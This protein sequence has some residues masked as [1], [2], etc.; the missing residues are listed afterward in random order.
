MNYRHWLVVFLICVSVGFTN[1]Q[2]NIQMLGKAEMHLDTKQGKLQIS[3]DSIKNLSTEGVSGDLR[4][5]LYFLPEKYNGNIANGYLAGEFYFSQYFPAKSTAIDFKTEM[6]FYEIPKGRYYKTICLEEKVNGEFQIINFLNFSNQSEVD[7]PKLSFE[8]FERALNY[9]VKRS[10]HSISGRCPDENFIAK[11]FPRLVKLQIICRDDK[12]HE[13][14]TKLPTLKHLELN[15]PNI[16]NLPNDIRNLTALESFSCTISS[17][18]ELPENVSAWKNL[19]FLN[20]SY[21]AIKALPQNI[22]ELKNLKT[23]KLNDN[24]ISQLPSSFTQLENLEHLEINNTNI[25]SLP[26]D[27]GELSK[28]QHIECR[29]TQ[30]SEIPSSTEHLKSLKYLDISGTNVKNISSKIIKSLN[31]LKYL[32]ISGTVMSDGQ[33]KR[34]KKHVPKQCKVVTKIQIEE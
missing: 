1:A 16:E 5:R 14:I 30:I 15:M 29:H 13:E 28:I 33:V 2:S 18:K 19:S 4:L 17:L 25:Q 12:L 22:G 26:E 20:I 7:Y 21:T 11:S 34:I 3:I 27:I 10:I 6:P 23:L 9:K 24:E 8:S 32:N 31:A